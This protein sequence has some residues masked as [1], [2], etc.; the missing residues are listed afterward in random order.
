MIFPSAN[1]LVDAISRNIICWEASKTIFN[2]LGVENKT[3]Y[4]VLIS[5]ELEEEIQA[6][7][8]NICI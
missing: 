6:I 3:S 1:T 2:K 7:L 5:D 4:E 8:K